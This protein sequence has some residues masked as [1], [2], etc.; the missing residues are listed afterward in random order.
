MRS[1]SGTKDWRAVW[2]D[3][4]KAVTQNYLFYGNK[5]AKEAAEKVKE[6]ARS[7]IVSNESYHLRDN[8]AFVEIAQGKSTFVGWKVLFNTTRNPKNTGTKEDYFNYAFKVHEDGT[9]ANFHFFKNAYDSL[10]EECL[11]DIADGLRASLGNK[12]F[13]KIFGGGK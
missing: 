7:N 12:K 5:Y 2:E 3:G 10:K 11:K 6:E 1:T 8:S 4:M 9:S 13:G